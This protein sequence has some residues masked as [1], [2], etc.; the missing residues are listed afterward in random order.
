MKKFLVTVCV[1]FLIFVWTRGGLDKIFFDIDLGRDLSEMSKLWTGT[2]VIWLG[3]RLD[4]GFHASPLYYYLY[5]PA[6]YIARGDAHAIIVFSVL[7]AASAL[8]VFGY[9]GVKKW[10]I[11]G[12]LP[13]IIIGLMPWWQSIALHP[14]NGYTYAIFFLVF[15][16]SL[17]FE[18][19]LFISS[20]FLGLSLSFHPA[21]VFG[22]LL[23][24]YEWWKKNHSIKSFIAIIPGLVIPSFPI[25]LFEIITKGYLIRQWLTHPKSAF[26]L[27]PQF[28]N[29]FD[30][31]QSSHIN[32][33]I[34]AGIFLL[35]FFI[36]KKRVK[37]WLLFS[38]VGV[39]F[40]ALAATTRGH[41][42]FG[43]LLMVWFSMI[44]SLMQN[45]LGKVVL[46][47]LA[48]IIV[49]TNV[50]FA[51][52]PPPSKRSISKIDGVVNQFVKNGKINKNQK[53]A[54]LAILDKANKVPMAD[55]YRFFLRV[56]GYH[57]L[58]VQQYSQAD[59]LV[60]F[61]EEPDFPWAS[62]SSWETDQFGSKKIID[63]REIGEIKIA[64]YVKQ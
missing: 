12:I 21:A 29:L 44:V 36:A 46:V 53:I 14:G 42:L 34:A 61:V 31:T 41:Y 1:L 3:P 59:M 15:L 62:W 20:L 33:F 48:M 9:L 32:F 56:K 2:K 39:L 58:N 11:A 23:L 43:F 16:V 37:T 64:T 50:V 40:F 60:L 17:W 63:Q 51:K 35:A 26:Q 19:P 24:F 7:L 25:I 54:V 27:Q 45:T 55:D 5:Y 30:L 57:V 49:V 8:A 22:L 13:V 28:Q 10:G 4:P 47:F 6:L 52:T 38:L 18:L